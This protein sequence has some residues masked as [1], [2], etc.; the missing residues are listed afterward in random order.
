[1]KA[2]PCF[3]NMDRR[4]IILVLS[5]VIGLLSSCVTHKKLLKLS[6]NS[7]T[8]EVQNTVISLET[9]QLN[10]GDILDIKVVSLD[11]Q[12]VAIFNK[13]IGGSNVNQVNEAAIFL[14]GY[15]I[16]DEGFISLP[17]I[18]EISAVGSTMLEF[19]KSLEVELNK[20]YKFMTVDV[21]L[22][23]FRVTILG[24]INTPGTYNVYNSKLS[25]LQAIGNAG[26]LTD[27]ANRTK[28]R[29]VRNSLNKSTVHVIDLSQTKFLEDEIYYLSPNDVIYVEPLKAKPLNINSRSFGVILSALTLLV[30]TYNIFI[31]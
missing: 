7:T 26:G 8:Q 20:Y 21:K 12:S 1:M 17:I 4:K 2:F 13:S 16:N 30:L 25:I 29:L 31:K 23:N 28:L 10:S 24:E 19:K 6:D 22:V 9:Y 3:F 5:F 14:N 18:G 11:Q 15:L 27:Y